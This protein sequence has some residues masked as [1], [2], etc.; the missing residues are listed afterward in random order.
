MVVVAT[1]T[2]KSEVAAVATDD[3]Q[4]ALGMRQG[5]RKIWSVP[6]PKQ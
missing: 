2:G 3:D 1:P 6:S 4:C 5:G